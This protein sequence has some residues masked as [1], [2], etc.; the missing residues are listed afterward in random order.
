MVSKT[1]DREIHHFIN[2]DYFNHPTIAKN[3]TR[4]FNGVAKRSKDAV[5]RVHQRFFPEISL[6]QA[7]I[8]DEKSTRTAD[9]EKYARLIL[10]LFLPYRSNQ[11]LTKHGSYVNHVRYLYKRKKYI[12]ETEI[13]Y[14]Q[15]VQDMKSNFTRVGRINDDLQKCTEPYKPPDT[16]CSRLTNNDDEDDKEEEKNIITQQIAEELLELM[17]SEIEKNVKFNM[18]LPAEINLQEMRM[19]GRNM[20]GYKHISKQD[21][22]TKENEVCSSH[23]SFISVAT[24]NAEHQEDEIEQV[25][26]RQPITRT[27][28]R[29]LLQKQERRNGH[30]FVPREKRATMQIANGSTSSIV[31][32]GKKACLDKMQQRAFEV[33]TASFVLTFFDEAKTQGDDFAK[34]K[35]PFTKKNAITNY[36]S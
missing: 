3:K 23:T 22:D 25:K 20:S 21:V 12:S 4:R 29:L 11:D 28:I 6:F 19:K 8:L 36:G 30:T 2:T 13:K 18:G 15:N 33:I 14:L 31:D 16:N 1:K 7:S 24:E 10:I 17:E 32:W 27:K 26:D 34:R 9:M 35:D 5:V